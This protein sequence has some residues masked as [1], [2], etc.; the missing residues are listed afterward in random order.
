MSEQ[1]RA[2]V[3]GD[4]R[5]GGRPAGTVPW[6]THLLAWQGYD[7]AGHGDQSA[8]RIAQ[9]GG[10]S[11]RELQC[12]IAGHYNE[13]MHGCEKAHPVPDGWKPR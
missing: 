5:I 6:S 4:G 7:A 10:F 11:Y 8:E 1:R 3:Q 13:L 12:A 9:R 2:P